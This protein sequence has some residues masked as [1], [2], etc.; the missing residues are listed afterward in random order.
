MVHLDVMGE[1]C[2]DCNALW[3]DAYP[4]EDNFQQYQEFM[5]ERGRSNPDD[6]TEIEVI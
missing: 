3:I 1:F 2:P 4:R 6:A 5:I